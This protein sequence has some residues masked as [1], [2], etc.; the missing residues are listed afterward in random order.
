M[1]SSGAK[2]Q[3]PTLDNK[4]RSVMRN[5]RSILW[6]AGLKA[7]YG[8]WAIRESVEIVNL[9]PCG[10][11]KLGHSPMQQWE[12]KAQNVNRETFGADAYVKLEMDERADRDKLHEVAAGGNGRYRYVGTGTEIGHRAKGSL[13]LD[14]TTGTLMHRRS[15]TLNENMAEVRALPFPKPAWPNVPDGS[16]RARLS[17]RARRPISS[18]WWPPLTPASAYRQSSPPPRRVEVRGRSWE[19]HPPRLARCHAMSSHS[20]PLPRGGP[21]PCGAP[22][23]GMRRRRTPSPFETHSRARAELRGPRQ[24]GRL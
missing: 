22:L 12:G 9:L 5:A 17:V 11:H 1:T 24:A 10:R 16:L 21:R 14:T 13:I 7:E 23:H 15:Y 2:N 6:C 20:P 18:M 3:T 8:E 4:I 19:A